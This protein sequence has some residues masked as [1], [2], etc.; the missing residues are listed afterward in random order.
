MKNEQIEIVNRQR[1]IKFNAAA[2][3]GFVERAVDAIAEAH[4]KSLTVAFVSDAKMRQLNR[5]FRGKNSTTDVL[6]FPDESSDWEFEDLE[7]TDDKKESSKF[8]IPNSK[9]IYLGDIVI[10]LEQAQRQ[11]E[12]NNLQ[13]EI[14]IKQLVLHGILH[15]CG[16]DHETDNGEMN[17][18]ELRLRDKL[19]I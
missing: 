16:Y 3:R 15:L 7:L 17:G 13:F 14:E 12:E 8:Q 19:G 2:F 4:G 11:A 6:S 10:S 5:Q 18:R 1:K 9:S